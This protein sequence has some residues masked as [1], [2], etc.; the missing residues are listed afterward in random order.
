MQILKSGPKL[1][2]QQA[3]EHVKDISKQEVD[4]CLCAIGVMPKAIN[5]TTVTLLPKITNHTNIK[6]YRPI[7]CCTILYKI[8]YKILSS[9]LQKVMGFLIDGAQAGFIPRRK[10][11]DNIILAHELIKAYSRKHISPRCM[12]KASQRSKDYKYFHYHP[13]CKKLGIT[14]L[15]FADDLLLFARGDNQ[16]VAMLKQ[17]FDQFS[18]AS[19]VKANLN[20]SS[21]YFGGVDNTEQELILQQLGY[22]KGELP[23]RYLGVPLATKKI[24]GDTMAGS[25]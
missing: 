13:K 6:D 18:I 17:Y 22:M 20:K 3:V 21:V 12:I 14:H 9:R 5:C 25:D 8:I 1:N 19:G 4:E 16:F 7:F 24:E 10:E 11:G 2:H 23:F 15:S